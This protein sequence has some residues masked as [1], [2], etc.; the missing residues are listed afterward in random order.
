MMPML[1]GWTNVVAAP[2]A[3]TTGTNAQRYAI[4]G[5]GWK[6]R[7][8][9]ASREYASPTN[10]VWVLG[11]TYCTG[12]LA[13]YAAVHTIQGRYTLVPLSAYGKRYMPP[14]GAVDP[15]IDMKTP[16]R[17]QVDRMN[18]ATYFKLLA[19]LM[20]ENPPTAAD[21]PMVAKLAT[22]GIVPGKDFDIGQVD[23]AVAQG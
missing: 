22:M 15:T 13:D 8:P 17:E 4:I 23:P 14:P 5:P 19:A 12:K 9:T 18:A 3:R 6:G 2:G 21:A 20:K 10:L 11:R 1:D 7:C 16:V